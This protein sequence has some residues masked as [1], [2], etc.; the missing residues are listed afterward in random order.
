LYIFAATLWLINFHFAISN[1]AKYTPV[2]GIKSREDE[3]NSFT[4]T[5]SPEM[6][7]KQA[8]AHKD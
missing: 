5:V 6:G 2:K 8:H 1:Y 4:G 7:A 3:E